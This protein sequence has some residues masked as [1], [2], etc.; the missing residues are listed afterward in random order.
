MKNKFTFLIVTTLSLSRV[1]G[2]TEAEVKELL[3]PT[4]QAYNGFLFG[5][6]DPTY[7]DLPD[8]EFIDSNNKVNKN[9]GNI[10]ARASRMSAGYA[11]L[12]N[13]VSNG[14]LFF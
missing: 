5:C 1:Y 4:I 12:T 9:P 7:G 6:S 11:L 2:I 3:K 10:Q 14:Q 13:Y 8:A